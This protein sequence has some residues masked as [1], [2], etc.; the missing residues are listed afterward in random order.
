MNELRKLM[1]L[2]AGGIVALLWMVLSGK[3]GLEHWP[4]LVMIGYAFVAYGTFPREPDEYGRP[5]VVWHAT[6]P[7]LIAGLVIGGLT[8]L[9]A[10]QDPVMAYLGLTVLALLV[11]A[12]AMAKVAMFAVDVVRSNDRPADPF[13]I[14]GMVV[15]GI[16]MATCAERLAQV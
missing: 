2:V 8:A 1:T 5:A 15:V 10:P 3:P 13:V 14:S 6:G 7:I 11:M 9:G 4:H 12:N 16:G